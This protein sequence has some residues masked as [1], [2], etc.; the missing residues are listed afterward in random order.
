MAKSKEEITYGTAQARLSEDD[1][2]RVRY[3][4]G[5][6]LEG[7]KIAESEPVELFSAAHNIEK[8]R[9]RESGE[10]DRSGERRAGEAAASNEGRDKNQQPQP[11]LQH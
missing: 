8:Q 9:R 6:P 4:G 7:G 3:K 5:D 1:A 2:L 10:S 11:Q